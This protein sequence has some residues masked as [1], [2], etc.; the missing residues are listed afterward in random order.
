MMTVPSLA[1]GIPASQSTIVYVGNHLGCTSY[2]W[3][4]SDVCWLWWQY[5]EK[6]VVYIICPLLLL[7]LL[8]FDWLTFD[9]LTFD[10]SKP[11]FHWLGSV[12]SIF[13]RL[14]EH[15]RT[16]DKKHHVCTLH[17]LRLIVLYCEFG[18]ITNYC[19]YMS[20][21][22]LCFLYHLDFLLLGGAIPDFSYHLLLLFYHVDWLIDSYWLIAYDCRSRLSL[23]AYQRLLPLT[24]CCWSPLIV[25]YCSWLV[26]PLAV[27]FI[28]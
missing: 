25:S 7:M 3:N 6:H 10:S 17:H 16:V 20:F 4:V 15:V 2:H 24:A 5:T 12:V 27:C 19:R 22:C 8:A 18:H 26:S 21:V 14:L 13:P 23:L 1:S 28:T 9:W 11:R